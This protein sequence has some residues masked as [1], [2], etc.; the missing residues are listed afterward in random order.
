[1]LGR[2]EETCVCLYFMSYTNSNKATLKK[3]CLISSPA[4][5]HN[6]GQ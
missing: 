2:W 6:C 1:M 3:I 5:G 4:G